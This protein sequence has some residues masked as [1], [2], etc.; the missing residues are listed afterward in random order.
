M[1]NFLKI[2]VSVLIAVI[3][4]QMLAKNAKD[5]GTLLMVLVCG[6][7]ASVA[8]IYIAP[9]IEFIERLQSV[10]NL[11]TALIQ[12]VLRAVGIG[13]L[14]QIVTQICTDAGNGALG[15]I[16]QIL[17]ATMILWISIPLFTALIDLIQEILVEL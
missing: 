6:M 3:M 10:G 17:S 4:Y 2:M 9:V 15:K 14:S 16:L 12:I 5:I 1:D 8:V 11:D 7:I 13:L